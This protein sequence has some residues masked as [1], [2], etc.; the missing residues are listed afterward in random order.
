MAHKGISTPP[1]MKRRGALWKS[2]W[3]CQITRFNAQF[4][5]EEPD[6]S[7]WAVKT[8]HWFIGFRKFSCILRNSFPKQ[9]EPDSHR[10]KSGSL[11]I[12]FFS[13]SNQTAVNQI[14]YKPRFHVGLRAVRQSNGFIV[15]RLESAVSLYAVMLHLPFNPLV[16]LIFT[17]HHVS[18]CSIMR[19]ANVV[20]SVVK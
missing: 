9:K 11:D 15:G 8:G 1:T 19:R 18:S 6:A 16:I 14:P 5:L 4:L 20:K 13:K 3:L 2:L 7:S 17:I 10:G 12:L